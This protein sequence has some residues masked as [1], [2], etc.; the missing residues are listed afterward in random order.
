MR[1]TAASGTL[2]PMAI[3]DVGSRPPASGSPSAGGLPPALEKGLADG[4][5]LAGGKSAT[6]A[7]TELVGGLKAK[8]FE[9]PANT[10]KNDV[11]LQL[12]GAL[13]VFQQAN[14]LPVNGQLNAQTMTALKNTGVVADAGALA[15]QAK[16]AEK[17]GFEK[18][19]SSLK[20]GEKARADMV[21]AGTPDTNFLDALLNQLGTGGPNEGTSKSDVKGAAQANEAQSHALEKSKVAEA[22]KA[23]KSKGSAAA[24]AKDNELAAAQ[25]HLDKGNSIGV[26]VNRGLR[27]Q[28]SKT[29]EKRRQA[30]LAG[31]DPTQVGILDEEADDAA[32]EG[33]GDD[34]DKKRGRG[35]EHAGGQAHGE[36]TS[37]SSGDKGDGAESDRG[38]A[39]SGDHDHANAQRGNAQTGE[40]QDGAGHYSVLAMSEQ[41]FAALAKIARD[42]SVENR[43]TTYSWD[44]TFHKPGVYG[45]GQSAQDLVHLVVDKATAFDP[46]WHK[47]QANLSALVRR[48][49]PG[50]QAPS[51]DDIIQAMRQAR[52]RD[53]DD[54]AAQ[55]HKL[56][57]PVGRA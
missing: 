11:A 48:M 40:Q 31:S 17:D 19:P 12:I 39:S 37:A 20:L 7:A 50:G 9:P 57:R 15:Q 13:K 10:G 28:E 43:A 1:P 6:A 42:V 54:T 44:V 45:A 46:V 22:K 5:L 41:A 30:A 4:G 36:E 33:A 27:A 8:G 16:S 23:D 3:R 52:A 25:Q 34:G 51:L 26:K 14:A 47:A 35:G 55:L 32:L 49:D 29:E 38:N 56:T 21:S 53:G 2:A 18:G 24:D